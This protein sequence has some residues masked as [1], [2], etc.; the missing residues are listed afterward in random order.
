MVQLTPT[1][2]DEMARTKSPKEPKAGLSD[3]DR[4]I[5]P[6]TNGTRLEVPLADAVSLRQVAEL[7]RGFCAEL[8]RL[9]RVTEVSERELLAIVKQRAADT[10]AKMRMK[11]Y[12][13]PK[14]RDKFEWHR[15]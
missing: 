14:R 13:S 7:I 8:D 9:S 2:F 6:V 3:M 10:N 4:A 15:K 1:E 12:G 11:V 5:G